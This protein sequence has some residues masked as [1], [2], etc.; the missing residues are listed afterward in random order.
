MRCDSD[1]GSE[2]GGRQGE[3][4]LVRLKHMN[5]TT[6]AGY[7][8]VVLSNTT[9]GVLIATINASI[10]LIATAGDAPCSIRGSWAVSETARNGEDGPTRRA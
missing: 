4:Q 9:L 8:W 6:A 2:W 7:K 1:P 10:L 5:G 3:K